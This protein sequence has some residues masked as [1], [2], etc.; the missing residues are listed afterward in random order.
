M[1]ALIFNSGIGKRMGEL[2][3]HTHKSMIKLLN[4]ETLF[5][6]QIRILQECGI[7]EF[8]IT[9]GPFEHQ[10]I[11]ITKKE[12]YKDLIFHFVHND[13]Y[14][15]TNYIYSFYLAKDFLNDDFLTLHGDLVFNKKLVE[16][17]LENKFPSI[18]L[19]NK[20]LPL[21]EKDF[22]ARVINNRI[23]EVG[24]NIFDENCFTFQPLYKL[25][26]KDFKVWIN[27]V[28]DF[29]ENKNI[30]DVYAENAFNEV[31]SNMNINVMSYDGFYINEI[32]NLDDYEKVSKEIEAMDYK[33]QEILY[34]FENIRNII[35]KY[36][37]K[38]PFVVIA[39]FLKNGWVTQKLEEF[40]E[41]IYFSDFKANPIYEDCV[42]GLELFKKNNCDSIIS[43]GGGSAIDT[44]KSIK[45]FLPL[46]SNDNFLKQNH[47]YINLKHICIPTTAGTGSEST[48]YSVIY[49]EGNKQSLTDDMLIPEVA[50]LEKKFLETLSL[51]QKKATIFDALCHSI[52]SMWSINS[53]TQSI[54]YAEKAIKLILPNIQRYLDGELEDLQVIFDAANLAGKAINISQ[55]TAAHALSYKLTSLYNIPHGKAVALLL[56]SVMQKLIEKKSVILDSKKVKH[57]EIIFEKLSILFNVDSISNAMRYLSKI[58]NDVFDNSLIKIDDNQMKILCES[59]N[60]TRLKNFPVALN[61]NDIYDIY[62]SIRVKI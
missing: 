53:N 33:E 48:R 24:I 30:F 29:I 35:G 62:S 26:Q 8:V 52:E 25:S 19:I 40:L 54:E 37:I 4:G 46:D 2:T 31:S 27:S 42:K 11:E 60:M 45:L 5:E 58:I 7:K 3:S 16:T 13:L 12:A 57:I 39:P 10:L 32:D 14:D 51:E 56:P 22:K 61:E 34:G 38:K 17:I 55:T 20:N 59:V 47:K 36:N 9:T 28:V 1:K 49:F 44:A 18:G 21:P 23:V 15:K 41:P 43:I 50:I 6:R